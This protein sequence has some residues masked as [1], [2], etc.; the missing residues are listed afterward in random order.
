MK[1]IARPL[2]AALG[3]VLTVSVMTT[4]TFAPAAQAA[5]SVGG[6]ISR[7]E[8][9]DRA[10]YWVDRNVVYSQSRTFP[11]EQGKRY[12]TDCS[13]YVALAW[14]M[15]TAGTYLDGGLNTDGFRNYSGKTV[16]GSV[17]DLKPGDALLRNGHIELFVRWKD[18]G[19]H[20]DGAYVHSLN[21]P[22]D[23]DWAKGPRKN[24]HG[25]V[26]FNTWA[27]MT[28]YTPI[29]YNKITDGPV[30]VAPENGKLYREPSGVIAV[31][32][33]GAPARFQNMAE[34]IAA[35]YEN[36]PFTQVPANYFR[37]L[38]QTPRNGSY[39][40]DFTTKAIS[41]VVG[42][43]KYHLSAAEW[44]ALGNPSAINAPASFLDDFDDVPVPGTVLRDHTTGAI[45][46]VAGGAR[47]HLSAAQYA[48]LDSPPFT[49]VP[50]GFVNS[51][52]TR[53]ADGTYLRNP[54]T[55]AIYLIVGGAKYHLTSM[56]E[57]DEVG[58][59]TFTNVPME[60]INTFGSAVA[61]NTY[62]RNPATGA[63]YRITNGTKDHL[64]YEEWTQLGQPAFTDVPAAFLD[65]FPES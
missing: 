47:Y 30:W 29:R 4:P 63:I 25:Q 5:S 48:A 39:V 26:G 57:L 12:R 60:W 21:G 58:G 33:G 62:L 6:S 3:A 50:P 51:L 43:A 10:Q 34:L 54:A 55:G 36:T 49:N 2:T 23:R 32:I 20:R 65:S 15:S 42:G 41:V 59:P 11:D 8:V 1:Q 19:D 9:L 13:G 18:S 38:P 27:E 46:I 56:A 52:P 44:D 7:E 37:A 40:R 35:G 17:H 61:D 24:S 16:L 28:T 31:I 22:T 14:H 53:P 64:T 45:H